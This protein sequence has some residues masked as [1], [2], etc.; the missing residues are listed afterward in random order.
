MVPIESYS[1]IIAPKSLLLIL[2]APTVHLLAF[3]L[4]P[5]LVQ[6][7]LGLGFRV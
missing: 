3:G 6:S 7:S 2:K 5:S 1:T 4:C